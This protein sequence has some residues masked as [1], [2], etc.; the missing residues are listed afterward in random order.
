[1]LFKRIFKAKVACPKVNQ[2]LEKK[3]RGCFGGLDSQ[4][5]MEVPKVFFR[6][7][8]MEVGDEIL[9]KHG[10]GAGEDKIIHIYKKI[11]RIGTFFLYKEER[12]R[13]ST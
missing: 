5:V 2:P 9:K 3:T 8:S 10:V 1:M 11:K 4:E 7:G 13:S 6:E 12:I